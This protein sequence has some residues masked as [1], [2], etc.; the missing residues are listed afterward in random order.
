ME[1]K[2]KNSINAWYFLLIPAFMF[3]IASCTDFLDEEPTGFLT[4]VA[5]YDTPA[6]VEALTIGA[7]RRLNDWTSSALDWGNTL[8]GTME[9]QTGK[10][11]S[12]TPHAQVWRYQTNAITGDMLGNFNNQWDYWYSGVRDCNFAIQMI[13]RIEEGVSAELLSSSLAQA[14]TLRAW[15]YFNLVRFWG[16]VPLVTG[17]ISDVG[18][19]EMERTS[20]KTIYDEV[21]L[22]DLLFALESRLAEGQSSDGRVTKDVTRAILA[23]V[24]LTMAGYPYQEVATDPARNW[25]EDGGWSMSQYPVN[26]PSAVDFLQKSKVQLDALY[27]KYNLGTYD[28]LR[29]PGMNNRGE[30]IFQAQFLSGT[31]HNSITRTSLPLMSHIA[32]GGSENGTLVPSLGYV[33]SYHPDDKRMEEQQMFFTWYYLARDFDPD[34][35]MV[36]FD[37]PYVFKFYDEDANRNT[38]SSGLNYSFY[39]YADILLLLSEVNWTLRELGQSVSDANITKGINEVRA[40]AE[41]T[42]YSAADVDLHTLMAERAYELVME[43]KMMWDQRRTRHCLVDGDGEFQRIESFFGHRPEDFTFA[44]GPMNL[45]SPIAGQEISRNSN[46]TQ[47]H[48]HLPVN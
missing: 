12:E 14:R 24:Y 31:L 22:P 32:I 8:P 29:D 4:D 19:A 7:Y 26:S 20:L 9:Y 10:A 27:G 30:A 33:N 42:P 38:G 37:R 13:S 21:I 17:I 45:L 35:N 18:M 11:I 3:L 5:P 15:Y 46:M 40:R 48:G 39:R 34:E 25:S 36:Q 43:N 41:L 23:D 6:D 2:N 47:N 28:D 44:F 1:Y 16:D